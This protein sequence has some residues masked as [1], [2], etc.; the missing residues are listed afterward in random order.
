MK[1]YLLCVKKN[2]FHKKIFFK[3]IFIQRIHYRF[4]LTLETEGRAPENKLE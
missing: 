3:L 1:K 4:F 2:S